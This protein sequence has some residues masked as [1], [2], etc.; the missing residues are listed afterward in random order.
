[1]VNSLKTASPEYLKADYAKLYFFNSCF[2][3]LC[4]LQR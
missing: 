4:K 2:F 1:M 3:L